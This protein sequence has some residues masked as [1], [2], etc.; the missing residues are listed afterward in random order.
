MRRSR[1]RLLLVLVLACLGSPAAMTQPIQRCS[2]ERV[3]AMAKLGSKIRD[4]VAQGRLVGVFLA[5]ADRARALRQACGPGEPEAFAEEA[6][7]ASLLF[8]L[9]EH[10][11]ADGIAADLIAS[12]R[13]LPEHDE[14]TEFLLAT[15]LEFAAAA[16]DAVRLSTGVAD[17][18]S[19]LQARRRAAAEG[20][21]LR[22][23]RRCLASNLARLHCEQVDSVLYGQF[24]GPKPDGQPLEL[25]GQFA[26]TPTIFPSSY[27]PGTVLA[28]ARAMIE[29]F[30]RARTLEAGS[31]KWAACWM[32]GINAVN[33]SGAGRCSKPLLEGLEALA[34][35]V[36]QFDPRPIS[37][38]QPRALALAVRHA[39]RRLALHHVRDTAGLAATRA[40]Y[41]ALAAEEAN[42]HRALLAGAVAEVESGQRGFLRTDNPAL[43][44]SMVMLQSVGSTSD[45]AAT[46][47]RLLALSFG[48]ETAAKT[49]SLP[50]VTASLADD[51]QLVALFTGVS[52]T[53]A[54]LFARRGHSPILVELDPG[55]KELADIGARLSGTM[56]PRTSDRTVFPLVAS[57]ILYRRFICPG[58]PQRSAGSPV[59]RLTFFLDAFAER[60]PLP[61][62]ARP[63]QGCRDERDDRDFGTLVPIDELRGVRW[64]GDEM[65]LAIVPFGAPP[66]SAGQKV[67]GY[68]GVAVPDAGPALA[69]AYPGV[70]LP[71]LEHVE[72]E[73]ISAAGSFP[74]GRAR[75]LLPPQATETAFLSLLSGRSPQVIHLA[76]HALD[77]GVLKAGPTDPAIILLPSAGADGLLTPT[78]IATLK[79][80]GSVV[81]L[82][83][84]ESAP[85]GRGFGKGIAS[86]LGGSFLSAGSNAVVVTYWQVA[87]KA[88]SDIAPLIVERLAAGGD[89]AA[90][91]R[92]AQ[93]RYRAAR[94]EES[95]HSID[96]YYWAGYITVRPFM[97]RRAGR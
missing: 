50:T 84:C 14:K 1:L 75:T 60:L 25:L 59:R 6:H 56:A 73:V 81:L 21:P 82:S 77:P 49:P 95:R 28:P 38:L 53:G 74:S 65:E 24:L 37:R 64:L 92:E 32:D 33:E 87:D 91:L 57:Q 85:P 9:G 7:M 8:E 70:T 2:Q 10:S 5:I 96:P 36:D 69:A 26:E 94:S 97:Q 17:Y 4:S 76:A 23:F 63:G 88:A 61:L 90:A 44:A 35:D 58:E 45:R 79:I 43:L 40:R 13:A 20:S 89:A 11:V 46:I 3:D 18:D 19:W 54:A 80:P 31:A 16:G 22:F 47:W 48:T 42:S 55:G 71:V 68:V 66:P 62:L 12:L 93:R 86:G 78:E 30:T 51:E 41:A 72:E 27:A 15:R 83:M 39:N 67:P 29:A 34:K 52:S